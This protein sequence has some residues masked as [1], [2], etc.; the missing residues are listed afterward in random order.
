M[1]IKDSSPCAFCDCVFLALAKRG[2]FIPKGNLSPRGIYP[3]GEFI[4]KFRQAS[5][6]IRQVL[7]L[8]S[9]HLL[10]N[11]RMCGR[12]CRHRYCLKYNI[13]R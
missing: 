5:T 6:R 4:P 3:Q 13:C 8:L 7:Y 1:R 12:S 2:E 9:H 11:R 10:L